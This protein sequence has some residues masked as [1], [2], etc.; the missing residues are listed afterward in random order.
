MDN[1]WSE[2]KG[3]QW[4]SVEDYFKKVRFLCSIAA[5]WPCITETTSGLYIF[6]LHN[7]DFKLCF[8]DISILWFVSVLSFIMGP[9]GFQ[10]WLITKNH[11][12]CVL[13]LLLLLLFSSLSSTSY[14]L[15]ILW[16][17]KFGMFL[18]NLC[19]NNFTDYSDQLDWE[20]C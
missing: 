20:T 15:W 16:I 1:L 10:T 14:H 3:K 6:N 7:S 5:N 13:L 17:C 8:I 11:T 9:G 19:C 2:K 18:W 12:Q 4:K